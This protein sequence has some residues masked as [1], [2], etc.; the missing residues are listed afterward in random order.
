MSLNQLDDRS[1]RRTAFRKLPILEVDEFGE[2]VAVVAQRLHPVSKFSDMLF[3][4][5]LAAIRT[6]QAEIQ[7]D[8]PYCVTVVA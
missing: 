6:D 5:R 7:L 8:Q 1:V 2:K 3:V 4:Y